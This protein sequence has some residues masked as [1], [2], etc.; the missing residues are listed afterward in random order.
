MKIAFFGTP[1]L[2]AIV[3]DEL[4]QS[5]IVP[6]LIITNPDALIGRKQVLTPPPVAKWAQARAIPFFQPE[7]LKDKALL[8]PITN[9]SWDLF[10]VVAYG[11]IIP[12][13]LIE[14]PKFG[15]VNL[16]PS[17]LPKFRGAS[18]IRS[19]ILNNERQTGVTVMLLD[20]MVD[21]GPILAQKK[22]DLNI[23][24]WPV[25]GQKLDT[26]MAHQGGAFLADTIKQFVAGKISPKEQD[27]IEA[28]FCTKISKEMSELNLD[29]F[30]LPSGEEAYKILLK[31]RAF[32]GWP[33]TFF[34]YQGK[35]IKIKEAGLDYAGKLYISK[36]IPEGKKEMDFTDYFK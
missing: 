6:N 3:L 32:S 1:E 28:T 14:L 21:H 7:T 22:I 29:P 31:I 18:P 23:N 16:H 13:W 26:M 4:E 25:D 5:G 10:I 12:R 30:N 17:L 11:K 20:E 15:T 35:R 36:I 9:S 24:N 27:H 33:E 2:S 8:G 19:A 34:I